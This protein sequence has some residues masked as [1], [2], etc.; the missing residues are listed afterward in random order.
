MPVDWAIAADP[1]WVLA[2]RLNNK[3]PGLQITSMRMTT[4]MKKTLVPGGAAKAVGC[5]VDPCARPVLQHSSDCTGR[6][7][8][9]GSPG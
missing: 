9:K 2:T 8:C 5:A 4:M 6:S 3:V 1:T 7:K